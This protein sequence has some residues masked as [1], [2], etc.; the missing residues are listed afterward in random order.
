[1]AGIRRSTHAGV[2][3]VLVT[4]LAG[5]GDLSNEDLEFVAVLP[6]SSLSVILP[7]QAPAATMTTQLGV[8]S[9]AMTTSTQLDVVAQTV[10]NH[11][12]TISAHVP[13]QRSDGHRAWGPYPLAGYQGVAMLVM[14]RDPTVVCDVP[15]VPLE[16]TAV[17][18]R[19]T[20][21]IA[22]TEAGPFTALSSGTV[23]GLDFSHS[24]GTVTFD[25]VV[26]RDFGG[27][28][29]DD[30]PRATH[31]DWTRSKLA[32]TLGAT[33]DPSPSGASSLVEDQAYDYK[34][35]ATS[36]GHFTYAVR[37]N[38]TAHPEETHIALS[39]LEWGP[40][41][42]PW[43]VDY[44]TTDELTGMEVSHGVACGPAFGEQSFADTGVAPTV[45]IDSS[46]DANCTFDYSP[47]T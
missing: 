26:S 33:V 31:F 18:Y 7:A 20:V 1:M 46:T 6:D 14:D 43:R 5:C 42:A 3:L 29:T 36:F 15:D 28:Q 10:V 13:A 44:S 22:M 19:W 41:G 45:A 37:Y 34:T 25:S 11:V 9:G 4:A 27:P 12:H 40:D 30:D 38:P 24:C 21:N 39:T 8:V 16:S 23:R 35:T 17:G 47:G 2:L 32:T